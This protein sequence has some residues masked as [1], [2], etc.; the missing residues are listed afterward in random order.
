M[1]QQNDDGPP[2]GGPGCGGRV[3]VLGIEAVACSVAVFLRRGF[4]RRYLAGRAAAVVPLLLTYGALW[5]GG[6]RHADP[7]PRRD[8]GPVL[9]FLAAFL[10]LCVA[11]RVA[12]VVRRRRDPHDEHSQYDGRPLLGRVVPFLGEAAVKRFVEPPV[13]FV[14]GALTVAWSEPLGVYLIGAAACLLLRA[15]VA[16]GWHRRRAD[17]MADSMIEQRQLAER[18]RRPRRNTW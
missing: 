18:V 14:A 1:N 5:G 17:D 13:V 16:E 8:P 11:A 2:P 7:D 3:F 15:A 9:L 6:R 4:G 10:A 12:G